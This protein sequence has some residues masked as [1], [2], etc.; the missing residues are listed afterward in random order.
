VKGLN[1]KQAG[2]ELPMPRL[3]PS[4]S[5]LCRGSILCSKCQ[6]MIGEASRQEVCLLEAGMSQAAGEITVLWEAEQHRMRMGPVQVV[7]YG[8]KRR[9][10]M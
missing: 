4:S 2:R 10:A 7:R 1:D 5:C 6:H 8:R 9:Y 3:V